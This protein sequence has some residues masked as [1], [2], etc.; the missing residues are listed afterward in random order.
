MSE[1]LFASLQ[2]SAAV[3][4]IRTGAA[5][6]GPD[7][8]RTWLSE[9]YYPGQRHLTE[10]RVNLYRSEMGQ[11]LWRVSELRF[12]E[13]PDGRR[14]L[15]NGYT[16]LHALL[17]YGGA[18]PFTLT[19]VDVKDMREAADEYATLDAHRIRQTKDL[20]KGHDLDEV[21]GFPI[22]DQDKVCRTAGVVASGF[23]RSS[24]LRL[25]RTIQFRLP[26][27]LEWAAYARIL[28]EAVKPHQWGDPV[29]LRIY[30]VPILSV[31]LVTCRFQP[32]KAQEFWGSIAADD[33]LRRHQP[34]R[35]MRDFLATL[36]TSSVREYPAMERRVA[37]CWNAH[38]EQRP[39]AFVKV[40]AGRDGEWAPINLLGTPYNGRRQL[41]LYGN[42][43]FIPG[44]EPAALRPENI[45]RQ[46]EIQ[47][48]DTR[49][50]AYDADPNGNGGTTP[51]VP[52]GTSR[53]AVPA[54]P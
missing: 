28:F 47:A 31:A 9:Y 29:A 52:D 35:M 17:Q 30:N 51:E 22:T 24:S 44:T 10:G 42:G 19:V 32:L 34:N 12:A 21:V 5:M 53:S 43:T 3:P 33:G 18:Q 39:M 41:V 13:L 2:R 49:P 27:L 48:E 46:A 14:F 40:Q 8:A 45:Y 4:E 54:V 38:M 7:E 50:A 6:I 16:R 1:Q 25:A 15:M 20:L 11:G 37:A 36:S 26:Y 23:G